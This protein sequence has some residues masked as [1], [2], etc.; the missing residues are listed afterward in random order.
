MKNILKRALLLTLALVMMIQFTGCGGGDDV[1]SNADFEIDLDSDVLITDKPVKLSY[2]FRASK[3][4]DGQYGTYKEA[5]KMTGVMLETTVSKSNSDLTQAFNLMLASGDIPDIVFT[6][7]E[8]QFMKYG[9]DGAFV[10]LD[11]HFDKMPNFKAFLEENPVVRKNLTAADGHIYYLPF[12]PSGKASIGWFVREDW[13]EKLGLKNPTNAEELYEVLTAFK[14][15]DPNGNGKADEVPFFGAATQKLKDLFP[16]WG[17][18][19]SWFVEDGKVKFGPLEP[20]FKTAMTNVIKWYKEGLLDKEIITIS[21]TPRERMLSENI[22][23]M[24]T[25]WFASTSRLN[26]TIKNVPGL[27]FTPFAPP[28]NIIVSQRAENANYGWGI[29]SGTKYLDIAVKYLDFWFSE[30]GSNL[31]NFGKEGEHWNMVDGK[32]QFTEE[33]LAKDNPQQIIRD[34]GC[35]QGIGY[36]QNFDYELQWM[37]QIGKDGMKMYEEGNWFAEQM[38]PVYMQMDAKEREEYTTLK[39]NIETHYDELFQKWI[40]GSADFEKGYDSFVASI[41]KLGVDRLLELQNNAYAK[42]LSIK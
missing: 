30:K 13:M 32:P 16:L 23:G 11:E 34:F 20:E 39:T 42:Y 29:Y 26:D 25:D 33:L 18:R 31:I 36:K 41:K 14:T 28:E 5:A 1:V 15:Q 38:P 35:Q 3:S 21:K 7:D 37:N 12:C 6:Q 27:K 10:A 22:G 8:L 17:A 24:T 40:L 19:Q 9:M 2:F 4:D